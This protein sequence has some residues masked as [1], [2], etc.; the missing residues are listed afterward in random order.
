MVND[1]L[2]AYNST[3]TLDIALHRS[4]PPGFTGWVIVS[5]RGCCHREHIDPSGACTM[6]HVLKGVKIFLIAYEWNPSTSSWNA[7]LDHHPAST[8]ENVV[9][10]LVV[11]EEGNYL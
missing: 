6:I 7:T 4:V 3:A 11:I 5:S 10:D 2:R 1:G 8:S 9:Y